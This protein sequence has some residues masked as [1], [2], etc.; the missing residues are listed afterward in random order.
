[1]SQGLAG[2]SIQYREIVAPISGLFGLVFQKKTNLLLTVTD[3]SGAELPGVTVSYP[4]GSE[5]VT[6]TTSSTS[7]LYEL[8]IPVNTTTTITLSKPGYV[9]QQFSVTIAAGDF[10]VLTRTMQLA[11]TPY[12]L[13]LRRNR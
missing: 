11:I 6:F 10:Q 8:A 5:T 12:R 7:T 3:A 1:M 2:L 13:I 4:S 9:T